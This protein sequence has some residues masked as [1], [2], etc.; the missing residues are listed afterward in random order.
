SRARG[1][2]RGTHRRRCRGSDRLDHAVERQEEARFFFFSSRRRHTSFSR[3]WS[4]DVCSSDLAERPSG[5]HHGT[6]PGCGFVCGCCDPREIGRA[7]CRERVW[8]SVVAGSVKKK[9]WG[10]IALTLVL[11]EWLEGLIGGGVVARM[12]AQLLSSG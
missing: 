12:H 1:M 3:D 7:S 11:E 9:L 8:V 10:D 5:A 2:A 6:V 4:S